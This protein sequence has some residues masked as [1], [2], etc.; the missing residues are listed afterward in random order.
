MLENIAQRLSR[1]WARVANLNE[2]PGNPHSNGEDYIPIAQPRVYPGFVQTN[3][4][5]QLCSLLDPD[6]VPH[7]SIANSVT[8]EQ[9]DRYAVEAIMN[10]ND[11]YWPAWLDRE[12]HALNIIF[13]LRSGAG[14]NTFPVISLE[15]I[16]G[17]PPE[18]QPLFV[19]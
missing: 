12:T 13:N 15:G 3:G 8:D 7:F 18:Y 4:T 5:C 9:R 14:L 6:Q 10:V 11:P 17:V 2:L 1:L 16:P 19:F